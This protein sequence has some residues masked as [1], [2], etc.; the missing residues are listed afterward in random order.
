MPDSPKRS[1]ISDDNSKRP[2]E[3]CKDIY[4]GLFETYRHVL[5]DCRIKMEVIKKLFIVDSTVISLFKDILRVAGRPRK[6]GKSKG[7]IKAY[8]ILH[9]AELLP[10]LVR[11]TE[12]VRHESTFLKHLNVAEGF[13]IV[14]VK[15]I[16]ITSSMHSGVIGE[17][18]LLQG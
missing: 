8:I 10:S 7:G 18:I 4:M 2:S 11:F 13:Y 1:T 6:Y 16:P 17:S 9:A 5:S 3:V 12:D 14:M 15:G